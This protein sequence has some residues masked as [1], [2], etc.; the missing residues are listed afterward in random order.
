MSKS[1]NVKSQIHF[2]LTFRLSD[3][4]TFRLSDLKT[5]ILQRCYKLQPIF[6]VYFSLIVIHET[7]SITILIKDVRK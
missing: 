6:I 2:F 1:L 4:P 7:E 3:L 5:T